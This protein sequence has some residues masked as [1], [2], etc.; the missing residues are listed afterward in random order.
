MSLEVSITNEQKIPISVKP[1]TLAGKPAQLDGPIAVSVVS[2]ESTFQM[3]DDR[4]FFLISGDNPGDTTFLVEGDADLGEGT[5]EVQDTIILHVAG[6]RA[7][8]LGMVAGDPVN[9]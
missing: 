3:V 5:E 9:K 4:S 8:N 7:A 1:V 6:A 2:G